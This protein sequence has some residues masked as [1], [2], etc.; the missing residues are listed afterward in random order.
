[1]VS[2]CLFCPPIPVRSPP[3]LHLSYWMSSGVFFSL[4]TNWYRK[5]V[6]YHFTSQLPWLFQKF[7]IG[8]SV[9][10]KW[11][12]RCLRKFNMEF[13]VFKCHPSN[14]NGRNAYECLLGKWI[15]F[16]KRFPYLYLEV[17]EMIEFIIPPNNSFYLFLVN[18]TKCGLITMSRI[19]FH[20][21]G[22]KSCS[23]EG[24]SKKRNGSL[25]WQIWMLQHCC[26][27]PVNVLY[28]RILKQKDTIG[29]LLKHC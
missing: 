22:P 17:K 2:F 7:S 25:L 6:Q 9:A 1:M 14:R 5:K 27:S 19:A 24:L 23:C 4:G 18:C 3:R 28:P 16:I 13:L 12:W 11:E 15:Y 29:I 20:I 26:N 8:I 10:K 21:C